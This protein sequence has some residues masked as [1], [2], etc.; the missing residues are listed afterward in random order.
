MTTGEREDA[1]DAVLRSMACQTDRDFELVAAD[2]GSSPAA[3]APNAAFRRCA[4]RLGR[5][6]KRANMAPAP[7]PQYETIMSRL[8]NA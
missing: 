3:A 5:D 7:K 1:L 2:D 6:R 8:V 4:K